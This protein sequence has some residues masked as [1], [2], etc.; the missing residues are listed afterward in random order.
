MRTHRRQQPGLAAVQLALAQGVQQPGTRR[1][2]FAAAGRTG[3]N[4]KT[5]CR[6][7]S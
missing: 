6:D 5:R 7:A 3:Q 1:R 4:D 2:R